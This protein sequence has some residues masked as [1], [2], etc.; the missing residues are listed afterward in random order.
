MLDKNK[1]KIAYLVIAYMDPEQLKRLAKRLT[2]DSDVYVH[3]NASVD[4]APFQKALDGIQ[5]NGTVEFSRERY[6]IV[7]GGFSILKAS[8]AMMEQALRKEDYDR[9]VL[10]TGLDYPICRDEE[11]QKFFAEHRETEFIHAHPVSGDEPAFDHLYYH[12]MRDHRFLHKCL[13]TYEKMLRATGRKGKHDYVMHKG[14]KYPIYGIA[15]KWALSGECAKYLL[16]FYKKEKKF[17]R[18]FQM[19]HAPDDFYVAT[20]L[21]NSRFRERIEAEQDI[22]KIVWLPEDKGAKILSE[23]DA[24]EL[25]ACSQLYA[26]KFQS[27]Y[28]EGLQQILDGEKV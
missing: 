16:D 8:F 23:E 11:I 22:F 18:Y 5:G 1:V 15:P 6:K 17:N 27:G 25:L 3:I 9:I 20:V 28:S 26:K 13:Q 12:A 4:I 2:Q 14:E 19:M 21:F 7:W 24:P 10:L